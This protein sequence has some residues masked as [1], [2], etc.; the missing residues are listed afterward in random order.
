MVLARLRKAKSSLRSTL[1]QI[2]DDLERLQ[3][4]LL[5]TRSDIRAR[6]GYL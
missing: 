6:S 1:K 5:L 3:K 4:N 2:D